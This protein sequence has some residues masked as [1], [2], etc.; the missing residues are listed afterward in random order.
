MATRLDRLVLLL[1]TGNVVVRSTAAEQLA[2]VQ[3][4]HPH[5]LFNLLGRIVPYLRSKQWESRVA[6]AKAIGGILEHV[7]SWPPVAASVK[8]EE[9]DADTN[10]K[11]NLDEIKTEAMHTD[12]LDAAA[13][14]DATAGLLDLSTFDILSV[15]RNGKVLVG[16]GGQ[17]Y[18]VNLGALSVEER[19]A[20]AKHNVTARLGLGAEYLDKDFLSNHDVGTGASTP[21][22]PIAPHPPAAALAT[23]SEDN[24]LA[25]LSARQ[26]NMMKRKAKLSKQASG[27]VRLVEYNGAPE[28]PT[29]TEDKANVNGDYFSVTTQPQNDN[30]VVVESGPLKAQPADLFSATTSAHWPLMSLLELLII[31]I[32]DVF[33]ETRH[34]A[35]IALRE[36]LR[37]H[38]KDVG[39]IAGRSVADNNGLNRQHLAD[40]ACRLCCVFA[41][42]R[43]GDYV[44]DQVV[45]P[46]RESIAQTLSAL[47]IHLDDDMVSHVFGLLSSLVKQPGIPTSAWEATH[48][49]MLGMRYLIA[50]R[51]DAVTASPAMMDEVMRCVFKALEN[52][53]DDVK[54]VAASSLIPIADEI[55]A[56]RPT[57]TDQLLDVLWDCLADLQDD[58]SSSTGSVIDLLARLCSKPE[59]LALM[60]V[61]SEQDEDRTIGSLVPLLYPFLRH[62]IT[63]VRR[64]VV[65]ALTTLVEADRDNASSWIDLRCVRLVYQ[66]L[67]VEQQSEVLNA[68]VKLFELYCNCLG[69]RAAGV[70]GSFTTS[71]IDLAVTPIGLGRHNYPLAIGQMINANGSIMSPPAL[72]KEEPDSDTLGVPQGVPRGRKRKAANGKP[73]EDNP[74][75]F[76]IDA[77]MLQGD[78]ELMGFS[79]LLRGRL[80]ACDAAG[81]ALSL[82]AGTEPW[83]QAVHHVCRLLT[84]TM[85]TT[86]YLAAFILASALQQNFPPEQKGK[87]RAD[88]DAMLSQPLPTHY[89]NLTSSIYSVRGQAQALLNTFIEVARLPAAKIKLLPKACV[90]DRTNS[91]IDEVFDLAF[92]RSLVEEGF[93]RMTRACGDSF[94]GAIKQQ[95][96]SACDSLRTVLE[97][98]EQQK[99]QEDLRVLA[100]LGTAY[101]AVGELPKKLNPVI[102]SLM[103]AVKEEHE[104]LLQSRVAE[105]L[106]SLVQQCQAQGRASAA[107]KLIKNVCA[108]SCVDTRLTPE[109]EAHAAIH[110]RVYTLALEETAPSLSEI[111]PVTIKRRGAELVLACFTKHHGLNLFERLP[112]LRQCAFAALDQSFRSA[113]EELALDDAVLGQNVIDSV[114]LLATIACTFTAGLP[115]QFDEA[116]PKIQ[117]A[118]QSKY[119]AVRFIAASAFSSICKTDATPVMPHVIRSVLPMLSDAGSLVRRQGAIELIH[120]LVRRLDIDVLPYIVFLI[121]PT[122]GRMSDPNDDIRTLATTTFAS[123]VKLVPL[124][125]GLPDPPGFSEELLRERDEERKFIQQMLDGTKVENFE[126]PV[127]IKADLRSYQQDGVNWLAFLNRYQLHGILCDDMGLGKTLQ[128]ICILASDHHIRA[129]RF[130]Q[131]QSAEYR[132][133]PSIV[134]CP[135]SLSGH[136]LFEINQYAPFL[137]CCAYVGPPVERH[138]L[139][140]AARAADIVITSYDVVR[141]DIDFLGH[142]DWNYCILDEG[143]VIKNAKAKITQCVK[144]LKAN[145]RLILS[146]TPIQNN[147]LELWSLFDFLMPGFL[148][149]EKSFH[150]RYAKPIANSRDSKSSSKEQEAGALALEALHKQVL[151]F[152]LRRLKEDV[153]SDLPPKII[154]DYYC[155]LSELQ[156]SLYNDFKKSQGETL[157]DEVSASASTEVAAGSSAKDSQNHIFQALQYMRK[158]CN[159]PALV[160]NAAHPQFAKTNEKLKKQGSSLRDVQH[161]PKLQALHDLLVDC[162]ISSGSHGQQGQK[163]VAGGVGQHRALIFFQLREMLDIVEKDLLKALLPDV[164]YMRLDGAVDPRHRQSIVQ[165]FN[166]DPSIDV[167]LL[168]THVGGLGLNLTGADTVIF[169]EHDWNPMKDLQAMD[170]AHRIGQ[171]RVVN[172]YRLITRNTLEEKIMGL[173]KFKMN[174]ASTIVNQQNS[175]L[176]T[177]GTDQ[178][179]DLFDAGNEKSDIQKQQQQ[180][181]QKAGD[182]SGLD[183]QGNLVKP[184]EKPLFDQLDELHDSG[185]YQEYEDLDGFV[186]SLK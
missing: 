91:A 163:E 49:G 124:E 186:A 74:G 150:D 126:I 26:R 22:T 73:A 100:G 63:G 18:D 129:E 182:A 20:R 21:T 32:F 176:A 65:R 71:L 58:L 159:H 137:T 50:V 170:R 102:K 155:E 16:S 54:A 140:K 19:L 172:V 165:Q 109:F 133:L 14:D 169:V 17:E 33:W 64:S 154:Q 118:L 185:Q 96:E 41:L 103:D 104:V 80:L 31:D 138:Q 156:R 2:Q 53:D 69:D 143:H 78:L 153:L 86:R 29:P 15:V 62:T 68:S 81:R 115:P 85:S 175:G 116:I 184:G 48:G 149:T 51:R 30:K 60:R 43:F 37:T 106:V 67:L 6:A 83:A 177:M 152:L 110:D 114:S 147:V 35:A 84:S 46:I 128:S 55:V 4:N 66:N 157:A 174:I 123:L 87:L 98:A 108:F 45:A 47:L 82:L 44:A 11:N 99:Q 75:K 162:G 183:L 131:T 105:A 28:T 9:T 139:Q 90:G 70:I 76:N 107:D 7:E 57:E 130:S 122:L 24:D 59:V 42:D 167:L 61:K 25:G 132:R 77:S 168:T 8:K 39:R 164:T 79:T 12:E 93:D 158:L 125:A 136:W 5:E 134:V 160:L 27:K 127:A 145:H 40:L 148:G 52:C 141:N 181:Q 72:P 1:D 151:P 117:A 135:P 95:C 144:R 179:L 142:L 180:Q 121:V 101:V 166:A 34:G 113:A 173:Q 23:S 10:A 92:A 38:A 94:R 161:A 119:S 89:T 97:L 36:L 171:K 112:G 120:L 3:K 178:L 146:G 111:T 56:K 13:T 88:L